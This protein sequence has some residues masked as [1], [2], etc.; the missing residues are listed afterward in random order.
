MAYVSCCLSLLSNQGAREVL[1]VCETH[2]YNGYFLD[3][4][5]HDWYSWD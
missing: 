3:V 2:A 5:R 1:A 4:G